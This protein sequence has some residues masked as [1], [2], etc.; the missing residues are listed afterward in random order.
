MK[1][2]TLC[3]FAVA[4]VSVFWISFLLNLY[5]HIKLILITTI[6]VDNNKVHFHLI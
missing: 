3:C 4:K 5:L 6:S 2:K 1:F